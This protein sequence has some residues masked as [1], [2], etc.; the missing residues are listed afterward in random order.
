MF[1]S[2]DYERLVVFTEGL[3]ERKLL[4]NKEFGSLK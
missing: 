1:I 3:N 2:F 4:I